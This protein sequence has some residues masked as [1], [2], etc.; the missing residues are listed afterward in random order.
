MLLFQGQKCNSE[1]EK[2]TLITH[3]SKDTSNSLCD[4]LDSISIWCA[5]IDKNGKDFLI[6]GRL[7]DNIKTN[8]NLVFDILQQNYKVLALENLGR[9]GNILKIK[10]N[11]ST[12]FT[13]Q[14]GTTGANQIKAVLVFSLTENE[15]IEFID[16]I[17]EEG[18]HGGEPGLHSRSDFTNFYIKNCNK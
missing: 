12:L 3:N 7:L 4:K 1:K 18:D 2:Q 14:Y 8:S 6:K 13:Q 11:N 16:L 9:D 10:I 15:N 5:D 17:F